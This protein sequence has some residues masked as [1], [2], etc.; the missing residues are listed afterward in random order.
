MAS[1]RKNKNSNSILDES[2]IP[3]ASLIQETSEKYNVVQLKWLLLWVVLVRQRRSNLKI[4]ALLNRVNNTFRA[5]Q[6]EINL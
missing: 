4:Y 2:G 1:L 5:I 3:W 6:L